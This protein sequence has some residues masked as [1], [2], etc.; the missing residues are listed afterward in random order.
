FFSRT[1]AVGA[2]IDSNVFS[3]MP[4]GSSLHLVSDF[5]LPEPRE[6]FHPAIS[7]DGTALAF[8]NHLILGLAD[9]D[10]SN[11]VLFTGIQP[12]SHPA[13]SPFLNELVFNDGIDSSN[14][15]GL[16]LI[17][18]AGGQQLLLHGTDSNGAVDQLAWSPDG[19]RIAFGY[20]TD[21]QT[22]GI[23]AVP[24]NGS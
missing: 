19:S 4:D 11:A 16:Q 15:R 13:W 2:N 21:G 8:V 18:P 3:V 12:I 22:S 17:D 5:A 20:T 7:P 6:T 23:I 9:P 1:A 14:A 24:A 10:G